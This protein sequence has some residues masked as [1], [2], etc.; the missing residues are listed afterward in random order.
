M[1]L[2][3]ENNLATI[4]GEKTSGRLLSA[5]S[6]NVSK[7]FRLALPA[8]VYRTWSGSVYEGNPIDPIFILSLI[9]GI[10]ELLGWI[11]SS[12]GLSMLYT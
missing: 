11:D 6:V 8:G 4:I 10:G 3:A 1:L 9:G 2:L 5:T 12:N 7:E